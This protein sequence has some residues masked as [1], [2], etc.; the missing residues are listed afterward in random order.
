MVV[1]TLNCNI[2]V[3]GE[4]GS[5]TGSETGARQGVRQ[6]AWWWGPGGGDLCHSLSAPPLYPMVMG[7]LNC[8]ILVG[9][10]REQDRGRDR[11]PG[12]GDLKL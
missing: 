10:E 3:G 4:T 12:G 2:L 1:G 8:N 11:E 6:G 7:T 9:Q 5:K